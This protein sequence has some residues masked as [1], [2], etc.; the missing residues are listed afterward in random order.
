MQITKQ[1]TQYN[2]LQ[3]DIRLFTE[4]ITCLK[5]RLLTS[6]FECHVFEFQSKHQAE[7]DVIRQDGHKALATALE[8]Y[9]VCFLCDYG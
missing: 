2:E 5:P 4:L 8:E 3:V 6:M 7:I 1:Q 9:K